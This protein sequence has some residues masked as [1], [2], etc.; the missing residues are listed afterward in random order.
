MEK[1]SVKMVVEAVKVVMEIVKMVIKTLSESREHTFCIILGGGVC[2][3][4]CASIC[5]VMTH[6][7]LHDGFSLPESRSESNLSITFM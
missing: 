3:C 7:T 4:A 6:S 2:V 1:E 5:V